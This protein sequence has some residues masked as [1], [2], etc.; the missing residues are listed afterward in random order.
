MDK[1]W[2][3]R[4]LLP[5]FWNQQPKEKLNEKS[6]RRTL[7]STFSAHTDLKDRWTLLLKVYH[8]IISGWQVGI[9]SEKQKIKSPVCRI[10]K[11]WK[12]SFLCGQYTEHDCYSFS[13]PRFAQHLNLDL[14]PKPSSPFRHVPQWS[15]CLC[16]T[17]SREALIFSIWTLQHVHMGAN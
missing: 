1:K 5:M 12:N 3:N 6:S 8:E 10:K 16:L 14:F 15:A 7:D 11:N 4:I 9:W 13:V 17:K 2:C